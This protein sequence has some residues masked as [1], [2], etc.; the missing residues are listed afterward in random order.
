MQARQVLLHDEPV[1]WPEHKPLPQVRELQAT[2]PEN[3]WEGTYQGNPTPPGGSIFR[4]EWWRGKNRYDPDD[5]RLV[6]WVVGRWISWDTGLKDNDSS[7]YTVATVGELWPDYR[8]AIRYVYRDR[9]EFPALPGQIEE[10]AIRFNRD[11]K[12]RGVLIEDKASGITAHQTLMATAPDWLKPL[13]IAFNPTVDKITRANQAAVWC[14][15]DCVLL[16]R[17]AP[18]V[19]WAVDFE[20]EIFDFP[21]SGYADQTDSLSQ[22]IIWA[23]NL[24]ADGWYARTNVEDMQG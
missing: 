4:R 11:D 7:A 20:E 16:P 1:L 19:P 5:R 13:L 22:L 24:L 14:R 8:L 12:L 9:I 10:M 17:P 3:I 21:N 15:N 6:N 18:T 2:T 23:E